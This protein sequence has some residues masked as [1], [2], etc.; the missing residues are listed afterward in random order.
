MVHFTT[1]RTCVYA[2][3]R[4]R[5]VST[6]RRVKI[7]IDKRSKTVGGKSDK[8]SMIPNFSHIF[9]LAIL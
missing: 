8:L 3:E 7:H 1:T 4:K 2:R 5:V 6:F 9:F